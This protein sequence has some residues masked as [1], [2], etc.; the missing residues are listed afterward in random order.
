MKQDHVL[1][2]DAGEFNLALDKKTRELSLDG[3]IRNFE[4]ELL[5]PSGKTR[6]ILVS[7]QPVYIQE[8][9]AALISLV[10]ITERVNAEQ[11]IHRLN[12]ERKMVEHQE[13]ERIAQLLHDDLQQRLFAIKMYLNNM[14]DGEN[15][16]S[17]DRDLMKPVEWLADAIT[18]TRQLS[19]D[20]S[21]L[22]STHEG[23][24]LGLLA[25]SSQ[26][27]KR[28]GLEVELIAADF[29]LKFEDGLQLILFQAVGELLFN[30]VK[31]SGS[32]KA[33]VTMKQV[34]QDWAQI[35]VSD[36]GKGFDFTASPNK[37]KRGRGLRSIQQELK[38]LGCQLEVD[39]ME[40]AGTRMIIH[41]PIG[42]AVA[43]L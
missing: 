36:E 39:S 40:N 27:K 34:D 30:I 10:D 16:V 19:T 13:R 6:S 24:A 41:I 20:L 31:H 32:L 8:T 7:T 42:D 26:M 23:F 15:P 33:T 38:L 2:H 25:L 3:S 21:P 1:E 12:I 35:I 29:E 14:N 17:A 43:E 18:L 22:E 11:E 4:K 37:K 5:L 28:Y 9:D